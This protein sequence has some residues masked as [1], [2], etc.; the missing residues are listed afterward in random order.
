M[1]FKRIYLIIIFINCGEFARAQTTPTVRVQAHNAAG[2]SSSANGSGTVPPLPANPQA[3]VETFEASFEI[4]N[5]GKMVKGECAVCHF[6]EVQIDGKLYKTGQVATLRKDKAYSFSVKDTPVVTRPASSEKPHGDTAKFTV[7]PQAA[8]SQVIEQSPAG[9]EPILFLANKDE[10]V[11]YIIG[12]QQKLLVR[13]KAWPKNKADEPMTKNASLIPVRIQVNK[14]SETNDDLVAVSKGTD[15]ELSTELS[16][17]LGSGALG[18]YTADLSMLTT[19]GD[20]KFDPSTVVL[21]PGAPNKIKMWGKSQSTAQDSSTIK[22]LIKSS[23][24]EVIAKKKVTVFKGV[25]LE[26]KGIFGA[27]IDS[28][29]EGWRPYS[30]YGDPADAVSADISNYSSNISFYDG[31]QSGMTLRS[32][33]PKRNVTIKKAS[34]INPQVVLY[35]GSAATLDPQIA[36]A[37]LWFLTGR[38]EPTGT[39]GSPT[40]P[41]GKERILSAELEIKSPGGGLFKIKSTSDDPRISSTMDANGPLDIRTQIQA[42][43]GTNKLAAWIYDYQSV[44]TNPRPKAAVAGGADS[45]L[46]FLQNTLSK[47]S[48]KYENNMFTSSKAAETEFSIG[49]KGLIGSEQLDG[50]KIEFKVTFEKWN[51]WTITGEANEGIISN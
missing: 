4:M 32:S 2:S 12:N 18:S 36:E 5:S 15:P 48:G 11:Q 22:I 49:A 19:D 51:G 27:P 31:D 25:K 47:A 40:D 1:C 17:E 16:I 28:I 46:D 42:A 35:D 3:P 33:S 43:M 41:S 50:K 10:I 13:D 45:I 29:Q 6:L 8:T 39:M 7:M 34:T 38:F 9:N 30:L 20:I 23:G 24:G 37:Q 26:F 14:T 21:T 44:T